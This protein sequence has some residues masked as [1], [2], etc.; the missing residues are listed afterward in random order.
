MLFEEAFDVDHASFGGIEAELGGCLNIQGNLAGIHLRE[1]LLSQACPQSQGCDKEQ[2]HHTQHHLPMSQCHCQ[3][4]LINPC[5]PIQQALDAVVQP[6]EA[7]PVLVLATC[8]HAP[9]S[10]AHPLMFVRKESGAHHRHKC[11]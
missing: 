4:T 9:R 1:E 2:P 3:Q 8:L 10:S 6:A 5:L 7:R 11:S